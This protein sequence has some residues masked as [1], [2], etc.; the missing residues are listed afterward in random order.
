MPA[1]IA[2]FR[3]RF[4]AANGKWI[5]WVGREDLKTGAVV[6]VQPVLGGYPDE[7]PE[8]SGRAVPAL[9]DVENHA[10]REAVVDGEHGDGGLRLRGKAAGKYE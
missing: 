3:S 6:S 9:Q 10:L 2:A 4:A 7:A 1:L 5:E 8:S